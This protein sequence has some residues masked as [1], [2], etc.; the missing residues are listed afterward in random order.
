VL[1][2]QVLV[3]VLI[4][5]K[6][7]GCPGGIW[8]GGRMTGGAWTWGR[9]S[10]IPG[11]GPPTPRAG[12]ARPCTITAHTLLGLFNALLAL[13]NA[14]GETNAAKHCRIMPL[15]VLIFF[16]DLTTKL[17][18]LFNIKCNAVLQITTTRCNELHMHRGREANS[19][20]V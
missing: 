6:V 1:C 17:S 5:G 12:P 9:G 11:A 19:R 8:P 3:L 4:A 14:Q 13:S 15:N 7:P 16:I 20:D 2:I 10:I 18:G